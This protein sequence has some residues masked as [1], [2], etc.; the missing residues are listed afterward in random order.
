[1]LE[2]KVLAGKEFRWVL[3]PYETANGLAFSPP[4]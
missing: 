1:M 3:M 2:E 4:D